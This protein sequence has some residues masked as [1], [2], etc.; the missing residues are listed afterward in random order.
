MGVLTQITTIVLLTSTTQAATSAPLTTHLWHASTQIKHNNAS[1]SS[2]LALNSIINLLDKML[3]DIAGM[4]EM[5]LRAQS[6]DAMAMGL[7]DDY[8]TLGVPADLD[9]QEVQDGIASCEDG[10]HILATAT[11][12][13]ISPGIASQLESTLISIRGDLQQ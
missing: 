11:D 9:A 6:T 13:D 2:T 7:I 5:E 10:L 12:L 3:R 4:R 8:S 1:L